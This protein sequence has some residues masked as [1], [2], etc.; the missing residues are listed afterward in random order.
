MLIFA[1][2]AFMEAV[3]SVEIQLQDMLARHEVT[4]C[5]KYFK[6]KLLS[7]YRVAIPLENNRLT[8]KSVK[9]KS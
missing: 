7:W 5:A 8:K 2:F 3:T 1:L 9:E 6:I 4:S